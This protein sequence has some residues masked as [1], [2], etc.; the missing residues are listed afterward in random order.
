M[1]DQ[2]RST[3]LLVE[4]D[5]N[6][7]AVLQEYLQFKG[8][9]VELCVDGDVGWKS[10]ECR[11]YDLCLLDVMMPRRDGFTLAR[12]IRNANPDIPLIFLTAKSMKE[13]KIEGL[14][15]GAD[16]YIVKPFSIEELLLRVKA[17]MRR[18]GQPALAETKRKSIHRIGK[19]TFDVENRTLSSNGDTKQISAKES[20]LLSV[21]CEHINEVMPRDLALKSIWGDENYFNAR[22]MDVFITRLRKYLKSDP[23]VKI[24]NIHGKGY[25]LVTDT[26]AEANE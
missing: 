15:I 12:A 4:D 2:K 9:D 6:L 3:V 14:T 16:D 22:S 19:F 5:P 17:V 7:G 8:Y 20:A 24:V 26:A 13:D 10:F 21:L 1:S 11:D 25:R 23:T 18:A